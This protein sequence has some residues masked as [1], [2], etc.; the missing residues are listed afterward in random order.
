MDSLYASRRTQKG[1]ED[2]IKLENLS[3]DKYG[4]AA[5]VDLTYT[6]S[7]L[8]DNYLYKEVT[9]LKKMEEGNNKLREYEAFNSVFQ[10]RLNQLRE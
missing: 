8:A 6:P 9:T 4:K 3:P 7:K 2:L 5:F 1:P 10:D